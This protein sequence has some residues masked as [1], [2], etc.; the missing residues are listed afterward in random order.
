MTIKK[1][2]IDFKDSFKL[3]MS[4]LNIIIFDLLF[5]VITMPAIF[6]IRQFL[7]KKTQELD[8]SSLQQAAL[9]QSTEQIAALSAQANQYLTA[10]IL[11]IAVMIII[12][13]AAWSLSRGL[14]SRNERS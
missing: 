2:L 6:L 11:S 9:S 13:L 14:I 12:M 4:F 5:P 7:V 8:M 10:I 3:N 1:Q